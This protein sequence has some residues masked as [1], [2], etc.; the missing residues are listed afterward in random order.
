MKALIVDDDFN[1]IIILQKALERFGPIH[2]AE[3]GKQ[4]VE[5]FRIALKTGRP[6]DLICLDIMMPKMDGLEAL[7]EIRKLEEEMG[8]TAENQAKIVMLTALAD[9]E[10]VIKAIR[11][12]C[13]SYLIKPI[14]IGKLHQELHKLG[15]TGEHSPQETQPESDS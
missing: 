5:S 11:L 12:K 13:S 2:Q 10:N 14:D 6:F 15:L 7:E 8:I 3:D 4:A 9:R 1:N